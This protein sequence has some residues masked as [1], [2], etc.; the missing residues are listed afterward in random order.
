M[1]VTK[2]CLIDDGNAIELEKLNRLMAVFCAAWRYSFNRLLE[3]EQSGRL[4]KSVSALFHL[5]KRY[6]ED[7]VM[8]AQA[9]I[10]SQKELLPLRIEGVQGKIKK[11]CKKIEDYQTGKKRPKKVPLEICLKGLSARLEKLQVKESILLNH[12][13]DRTIPPVVFG[14]KKNF[15]ERL[16][17]KISR[18]DWKDLR[19]NALYSRGDKSKKGNLN[20]RIVFD[21]MEQQFYLEVANPLQVAGRKKSPRLRFKLLVPDKFFNEI[22][23]IVFPNEVGV[24]SKKKHLE[25]YCPYSIE[26]KRKNNK[27]YVHIT[28]DEV[29]HGSILNWN[30][31]ILSDRVAGID[32]NIDRVAVS[33]LTKQ[34]NLLESKTFYCHEMEYVKSNRR[35]NISGEIA[36]DIIQY[37]LTWN[38]GAMVIEDITLKQDHDTNKRFN[39][40]V[41]SFAKTK[42][43]KSIISRGIK[44]G[45]KIKKVN[46]AYTSVIGRFKYS[47][48]Y[49]LS[50]HE[51][52]AF[53][54]GRRGLG[55]DEKIPQ[56]ILNQVRTLVKPKLISIL[57]SMEESEKKSKNGRQRRK[58][59]GML[60][61]NIETFKENHCWKLW[62][63]IHK[64]LIIKNQELQFKEV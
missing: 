37:L 1:R 5:N 11:T 39:R 30:E 33:I 21:D 50:V 23:E 15:Y 58:Y 56:E 34:G 20:T 16:K 9:I 8:Q 13:E 42:I 2:I 7:A 26:L 49:G 54:I 47:K 3:G 14:G 6:A 29:V 32:V 22:V 35:S 55:F 38:V 18:N 46:P 24:T 25:E 44:F 12:Q 36:K 63:V 19:S 64:T 59:M 60:L 31:M 27:V 51:A 52:A 62:N 41:H 4:I 53:V 40:L 48:K 17:G 10:S 43:Q 57:G 61:R 45:F 28:Y